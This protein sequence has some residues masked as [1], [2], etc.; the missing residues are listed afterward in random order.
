MNQDKKV[1][2]D[3]FHLTLALLMLSL[4]LSRHF[5]KQRIKV[6]KSRSKKAKMSFFDILISEAS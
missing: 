6:N 3:T 5:E 1:L 4:E 2:H